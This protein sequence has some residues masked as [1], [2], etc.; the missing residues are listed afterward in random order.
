MLQK[1]SSF[2]GAAAKRAGVTIK[3]IRHYESIG[4]LPPAP[5][6]GR[7]RVYDDEAIA[8]VRLIKCAQQL[9]FKLCEL[10]R[11]LGRER[12]NLP[13]ELVRAELE[14]KRRDLEAQIRSMSRLREELLSFE[15]AL[16]QGRAWQ[17]CVGVAG[18]AVDPAPLAAA[19]A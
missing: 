4:L 5:R 11:I 17:E 9:G 6:H 13:L 19:A 2:I 16:R 10:E 14:R 8:R 7:Y 12:A 18:G 1:T 3:A 15:T